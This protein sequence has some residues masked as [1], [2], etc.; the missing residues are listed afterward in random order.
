MQ[1]PRSPAFDEGNLSDKPSFLRGQPPLG[2]GAEA[3]ID[4]RNQ[5]AL[6]SLAEVDRQV[7]RLV[8]VLRAKGE[9]GSTYI[10]FTSDNGYIGGEH[11]IEFGK[12]LAYEPGSQMP[13]LMRGPGVPAG[14]TSDAL[15]G[16]ID[17]APTIAAI[18]GAEPTI[19]VDG[20]SLLPLAANPEAPSGRALLIESLVRDELTFYGYPYAAIRDGH[21]K[22]IRFDNGEEE[23]YNLA[24]DPYELQ[25]L[26]DDPAYAERKRSL[27]AALEQLRDC[28][29]R[30]CDVSPRPVAG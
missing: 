14:E 12:L 7:A 4:A 24:R 21:F 15:V 22:Y 30:G 1:A 11:R 2:S 3:R 23:L 19:E 16:N 6:E 26:A 17:L 13:L 25:S 27:A 8:E 10:F 29:G 18:A 28:R 20:R 9:L 5:G